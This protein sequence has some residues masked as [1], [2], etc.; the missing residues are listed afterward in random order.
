[1]ELEFERESTRDRKLKVT[2]KGDL[3]VGFNGVSMGVSGCP[4]I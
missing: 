4:M 2:E 3:Y 1:M